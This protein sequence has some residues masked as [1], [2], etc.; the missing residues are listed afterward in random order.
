MSRMN[1]CDRR[2]FRRGINQA[3]K[4]RPLRPTEAFVNDRPD[5]PGPGPASRG[6]EMSDETRA[7]L[8]EFITG[9]LRKAWTKAIRSGADPAE[10]RRL[11]EQRRKALEERP[12]E[13]DG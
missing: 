8:L 11:I 12:D 9:E 3:N 2:T 10:L 7:E 13:P 6:S 1:Y 4:R 5:D